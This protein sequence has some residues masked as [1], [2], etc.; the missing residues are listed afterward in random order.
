MVVTGYDPIKKTNYLALVDASTQEYL[1]LDVSNYTI[2]RPSFSASGRLVF[3]DFNK[4][5]Q[6]GIVK[7]YNFTSGK[8]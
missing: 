1:E 8:I 6:T 3:M 2:Y 7:T 5:D 4:T